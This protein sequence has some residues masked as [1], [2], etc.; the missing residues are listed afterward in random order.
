M[1]YVEI[2]IECVGTYFYLIILLRYLGKKEM[3]KLSISDLIVFLL[4]SELM[5]L[6]IGDDNVNFLHGA[7]AALVII[8]LDKLCSY[9]SMKFKPVKKVL[10]GHPTF[11]VYQ[12]KLNQEKMRALNYSV[13]DLCH[14]LREQGIGS[15]SEVEFA[16]LET[17]GQLSVIESQKSQV[18]MPESLINDGEINYEILQTMNRDEAWLKKQLHQHGVKDYRDIFYCVLEKERLFF[19]KK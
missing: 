11:I 4:I 6:S 12:G 7:L 9:V 14:H 15:L 8:L 1:K 17:D 13:D 16:V 10:E 5:T 18:D 3:G 2:F 19:I